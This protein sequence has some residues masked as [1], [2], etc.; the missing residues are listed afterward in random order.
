MALSA[1]ATGIATAQSIFSGPL[2]EV[3]LEADDETVRFGRS[4]AI[5]GDRAFVGDDWQP[6]GGAI[7]VFEFDGRAWVQTDKLLGDPGDQLG[8]SMAVDGD[9]L[10]SGSPRGRAVYVFRRKEKG[11]VREAKLLPDDPAANLIGTSVDVSI[12][13]PDANELF[14]GAAGDQ[15]VISGLQRDPHGV[16]YVYERLSRYPW[17]DNRTWWLRGIVSVDGASPLFGHCAVDGDVV[18]VGDTYGEYASVFIRDVDSNFSPDIDWKE[19]GHVE[20]DDADPAPWSTNF[21]LPVRLEGDTMAVGAIWDDDAGTDAGAAYVFV[22]SEED[23]YEWRCRWRQ[24]A[25]LTPGSAGS[26]VGAS[27]ALEG[28]HLVVGADTVSNAAYVYQR[29]GD[30]WNPVRTLTRRADDVTCE[31]ACNYGMEAGLSGARIILGEPG[32][33][34]S[35][36]YQPGIDVEFDVVTVGARPGAPFPAVNP[37]YGMLPI[38][39]YTTR[40]SAGDALDFDALQVDPKTVVVG[41]ELASVGPGNRFARS[42]DVDGDG[43][44]DLLL[45]FRSRD[46]GIACG[47]E[48]VRLLGET[49]AG[50]LIGGDAEIRTVLCQ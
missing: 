16:T 33:N 18:A 20:P 7:Y 50:D 48:Y 4:N 15:V 22:C 38:A 27:I 14:G 37:R 29:T 41:P 34:L 31:G 8:N 13:A 1:V 36:I 32:A 21:G 26:T 43:D 35:W 28:D 40:E 10:V 6:P 30:R 3:R 23:E 24:T 17:D 11:Y 2:I 9:L 49:Y 44:T 19:T 47:D 39:I 42:K 12:G 46:T 5:I 25:K 45:I